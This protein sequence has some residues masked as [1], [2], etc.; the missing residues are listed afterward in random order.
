ML[1]LALGILGGHFGECSEE[2]P[3]VF[4]VLIIRRILAALIFFFFRR[5]NIK[6]TALASVS[7]PTDIH[8]VLVAPS[9]VALNLDFLTAFPNTYKRFINWNKPNPIKLSAPSALY[10]S[11]SLLLK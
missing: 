4:L 5:N 6:Y 2:K 8:M 10:K 9:Y 3:R 11:V 7:S 1:L